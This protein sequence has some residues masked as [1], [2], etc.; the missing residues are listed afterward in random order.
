RFLGRGHGGQSQGLRLVEDKWSPVGLSHDCSDSVVCA[1]YS[2]PPTGVLSAP[3]MMSAARTLQQWCAQQ[4][5]G[6]PGVRITD[7]TSSFRDGLAFCALIHR[8]RPDLIDFG[9]LS[10]E[11]VFENNRL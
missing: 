4:C 11:N 8:Q 9:A 2:P 5:D 3:T 6:Y 1:V 10:K 7:L